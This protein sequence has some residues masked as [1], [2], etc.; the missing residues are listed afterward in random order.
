MKPKLPK[1][2]TNKQ[3]SLPLQ[4]SHYKSTSKA[5]KVTGVNIAS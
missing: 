1:K 2:K 3:I 5:G 4:S